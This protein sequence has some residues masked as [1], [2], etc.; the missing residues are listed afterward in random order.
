MS[1]NK[2]SFRK[3]QQHVVLSLLFNVTSRIRCKAARQAAFVPVL[4]CIVSCVHTS[5]QDVWCWWP[6]LKLP[7]QTSGNWVI[8][9]WVST[10]PVKL[11]TFFT[12]LTFF[13]QNPKKTLLFTFF[14]VAENV[15]SNTVAGSCRYHSRWSITSVPQCTCVTLWLPA[16]WWPY[17]LQYSPS[18]CYSTGRPEPTGRP[19]ISSLSASLSASVPPSWDICSLPYSTALASAGHCYLRWSYIIIIII[20]IIIRIIII[21]RVAV[22]HRLGCK[23]CEPH[24][25][26]W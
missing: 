4:S 8:K 15:F 14:W 1:F 19:L 21:M 18:I 2:S 12:F 6:W 22:A 25:C 11:R 5:E 9:G 24:T 7:V 13:F 26:V 23:A 10:W 20:I 17:S 16:A 3:C